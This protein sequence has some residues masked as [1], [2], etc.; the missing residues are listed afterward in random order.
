MFA[1]ITLGAM[2]YNVSCRS[3]LIGLTSAVDTLASQHNGAQNYREVGIVLQ[4]CIVI[5]SVF[6]LFLL[7]LWIRADKFFSMLGIDPLVCKIIGDFVRIR[8][9][10]LPADIIGESYEKYLMAVGEMQIPMYANV[11]I[12]IVVL[13]LNIL[14]I[15]VFHWGYQCLAWTVVIS[16]CVGAIVMVL[17]SLKCVSVQRTLCPWTMELFHDWKQFIYLAMPGVVMLCSVS[18]H[19]HMNDLDVYY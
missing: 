11:V 7:P 1:G 6:C 10:G 5:L 8:A 9:I 15:N 4:R 3:L 16:E 2:F 13:L 12:G 14:F 19:V 17:L 18:D